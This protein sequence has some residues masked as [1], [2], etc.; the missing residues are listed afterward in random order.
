MIRHLGCVSLVALGIVLGCLA[1][2]HQTVSARPAD[3]ESQTS[4]SEVVKEL[5]EINAHL[6]ELNGMFSSGTAKVVVV[7]NPDK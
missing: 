7:I 6:K 4:D 5:K 1:T 3:P 2:S